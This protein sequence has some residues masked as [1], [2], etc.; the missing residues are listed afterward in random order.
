[1]QE[2]VV[3]GSNQVQRAT[4]QPRDEDRA[5]P[6]E[7]AIDVGRHKTIRPGPDRQAC[8]PQVLCLHGEQPRYHGEGIGA[9][10]AGEQLG[11]QT[12]GK[13]GVLHTPD[14]TE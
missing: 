13:D 1:M 3:L 14:R 6:C 11:C 10:G 4:V 2:W 9:R 5:I 12:L 7:R 8:P